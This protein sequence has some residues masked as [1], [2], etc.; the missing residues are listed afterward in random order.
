[1]AFTRDLWWRTVKH[2]DGTT[3]RERSNRYGRGKRYLACWTNLEGRPRAKAFAKKGDADR[4]GAAMEADKARGDYHDPR[5]GD[6]PFGAL[7]RRWLAALMVDP[8]TRI[9]YEGIY[10]LHVAPAFASRRVNT[11]RPSDIQAHLAALSRRYAAATVNAAL[12]V[13][14]GVLEAAE[15]DELIAKNPA[16]SRVIRRPRR[17]AEEVRVWDDA[18]VHALVNAHPQAYRAITVVAAGCGMRQGEIFG[19]GV[20]DLDFQAGVIRVRRQI[21]KLGPASV[22]ALP[23]ND[24]TRTVP[25][26]HWVAAALRAHIRAAPPRPYTLPWETPDGRPHTTDLL[27]RWSDDWHVRARSHTE[28]VWKPA[29]A[30]AGLIPAPTRDPKGRTRYATTRGQGM[31]QLRHYYVS[32]QLDEG[33]PVLALAAHLG[34]HPKV[35]LSVYGHLMPGNRDRARRAVDGRDQGFVPDT[36]AQLFAQAAGDGPA[37]D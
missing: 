12:L 21:K 6:V 35:T 14:R 33:V 17:A 36:A 5:T 23:K 30:R 27:F 31:H 25:L 34:R 13:V 9:R 4:Y 16:Y 32:I 20:Q 26:P 24:K 28:T 22:F 7:A 18:Q 2:P 15:A 1:M 19:L 8:A 37:P 11:I 10:R 3:S 29:L